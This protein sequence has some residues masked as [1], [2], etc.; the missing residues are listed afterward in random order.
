[1]HYLLPCTLE[2]KFPP[3]VGIAEQFPPLVSVVLSHHK[4]TYYPITPY[5]TQSQFRTLNE[6]RTTALRP[7][8][9]TPHFT[10]TDSLVLVLCCV[11]PLGV[12]QAH[13]RV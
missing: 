13:Q 12:G 7:P 11:F 1:M 5:H 10:L 4:P 6:P 9:S 3:F 2:K 8:T